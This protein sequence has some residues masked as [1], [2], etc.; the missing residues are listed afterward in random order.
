MLKGLLLT[1]EQIE[2]PSERHPPRHISHRNHRSTRRKRQP[3]A[4]TWRSQSIVTVTT[5][6][7]PFPQTNSFYTT[8]PEQDAL[9]SVR[10]FSVPCYCSLARLAGIWTMRL[11]R[12][13]ED[14]IW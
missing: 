12:S 9:D 4:G 6:S 13:T 2:D 14:E 10:R 11:S 7:V 1:L 5:R 8:E 3:E